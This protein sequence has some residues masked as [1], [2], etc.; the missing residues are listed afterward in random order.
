MEERSTR[1]LGGDVADGPNGPFQPSHHNP[2]D[3]LW[4][5]LMSWKEHGRH[6]A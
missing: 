4:V 3:L 1:G 5:V 2:M 6:L